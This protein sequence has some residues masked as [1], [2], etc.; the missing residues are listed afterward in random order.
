MSVT[1]VFAR[2]GVLTLIAF[3]ALGVLVLV[4]LE[5]LAGWVAAGILFLGGLGIAVQAARADLAAGRRPGDRR[6]G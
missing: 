4:R 2:L 1:D 5:D 3:A 6:R